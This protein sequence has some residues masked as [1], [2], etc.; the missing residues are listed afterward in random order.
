ML[1][2]QGAVAPLSIYQSIE[3]RM[4]RLHQ[5]D[6]NSIG[7]HYLFAS[8]IELFGFVFESKQ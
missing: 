1:T 4:I 3:V 8:A 2:N 6:K 7:N 5:L